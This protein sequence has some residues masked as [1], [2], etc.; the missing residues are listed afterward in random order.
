MKTSPEAVYHAGMRRLQ[1]RFDTRRLADRLSA[2][3]R[4]EK[5]MRG[6]ER[7]L[8][9][10]EDAV[11]TASA[12]FE[13]LVARF[14]DSRFS[15][16]AEKMIRDCKQKLAENEFYV[17][18]FYF[19]QKK[20]QAALMRFET[21]EREY[22]NVGLDYKVAYFISETKARIAQEEKAEKLRQEKINKEKQEKTRSAKN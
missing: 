6:R 15:F 10:K 2:T 3:D 20:Y 17:G 8:A 5:D 14:P 12:E 11:A 19:K 1:D 9:V 7:A 16:L 4:L 18:Q 13:R 21:I 22:A